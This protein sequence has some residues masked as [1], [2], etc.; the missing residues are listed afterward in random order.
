MLS[1][2]DITAHEAK[3]LGFADRIFPAGNFEEEAIRAAKQFAALPITSVRLAKR[4]SNY[5]VKGLAEYLEFENS[6]LIKVLVQEN[7]CS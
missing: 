6:E 3:E 5:S 4:L 7:K 2:K 1:G